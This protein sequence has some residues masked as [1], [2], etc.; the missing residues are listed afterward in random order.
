VG[1]L[2]TA[3]RY[4][5]GVRDRGVRKDFGMIEAGA[6]CPV[7]GER[8]AINGLSFFMINVVVDK[9]CKAS[10][11]CNLQVEFS[12]EDKRVEIRQ[13]PEGGGARSKN[14]I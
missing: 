13:V 2:P 1:E 5:D 14:P 3:A 12:P 11:K 10:P 8:L 7:C 6:N 9:H 4:H